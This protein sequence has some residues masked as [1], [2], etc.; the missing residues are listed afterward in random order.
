MM[1]QSSSTPRRP[2]TKARIG[3]MRLAAKVRQI[4]AMATLK[5][6]RE[7]TR[8][9]RNI[10]RLYS[11]AISSTAN[12]RPE[13][14]SKGNTFPGMPTCSRLPASITRPPMT[15]TWMP[16]EWVPCSRITCH[17][18]TAVPA[19][20]AMNMMQGITMCQLRE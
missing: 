1:A 6:L 8:V 17:S 5:R 13:T 10:R 14:M 12:T 3:S 16:G 20:M 9:I 4:A 11:A 2:S 7:A 15:M 18:N 19:M